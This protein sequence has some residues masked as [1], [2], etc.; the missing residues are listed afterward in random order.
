M[1]MT[2]QAYDLVQSG[3]PFRDAYMAVK[4]NQESG[5]KPINK[6]KLKSS[7]GSPDNLE[8]KVLRSRL[9]KLLKP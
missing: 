2:D 1:R 9:Q 3:I 5:L 8:L 7:S 6:S 4:T